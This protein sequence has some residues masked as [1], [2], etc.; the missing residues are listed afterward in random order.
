MWKAA[1]LTD[2]T[3]I[4]T[5]LETDRLYAAYAIGDLEPGMSEQCTW[6]G[7]EEA[8]QTQALAL[9]FRGLELPALVLMGQADGL[10]AILQD[11]LCPELVYL[12]CRPEHLSTT[13]DFYAW[14][15]TIPMWRMVLR[16][17]I[18][19]SVKSDCVRI[20]PAHSDQL[21]ILYALGAG[22][23][24]SPSQMESGVFY[25]IIANGQLVAAA[26]THLISPT[27]GVAAVGN[28]FTHPD[29]RAQGYGAAT[30]SAVVVDL[31]RRGIRDVILNVG[32]DNAG[33]VGVYE[34]LG[35]ECYCALFE[36]RALALRVADPDAPAW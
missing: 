15:E 19:R 2:K 6:A 13:R 3:Q 33:A 4:L 10:R 8:G 36:G 18:F 14:D 34:H 28:V 24:Y 26:G 5:Y 21:G 12:T 11:V 7:A 17:G 29:H 32:Q 31:L 23:A 20:E 30:T 35:F 16:A 1:K 27:Y 9:H 22:N 25:G